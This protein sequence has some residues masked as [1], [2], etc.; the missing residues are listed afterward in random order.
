MRLNLVD[1]SKPMNGDDQDKSQDKQDRDAGQDHPPEENHP[2]N[3][4]YGSLQILS[5]QP[6]DYLS[7]VVVQE[8]DDEE[9]DGYEDVVEQPP[10]HH[11][12]VGGRRQRIV[13]FRVEGV[14]H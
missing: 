8:E 10:L 13:H 3:E 11:L 9:E 4:M 6:L 1:D 7:P 14:H 12:H 5:S 2:I